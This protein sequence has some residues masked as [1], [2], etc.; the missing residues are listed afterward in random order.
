MRFYIE[1]N[2]LS[3]PIQSIAKRVGEDFLG[4]VPR[5]RI[6]FHSSAG[7]KG[8]SR[9]FRK[10]TTILTKVA[11]KAQIP[12]AF[13]IELIIYASII[14]L[15]NRRSMYRITKAR[16]NSLPPPFSSAYEVG[17]MDSF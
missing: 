2:V 8:H 15:I 12:E 17:V 1:R 13:F 7:L 10:I 5:K 3:Y 14:I 16:I 9:L 11:D 4:R 6:H